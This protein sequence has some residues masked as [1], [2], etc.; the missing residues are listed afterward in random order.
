MSV[1]AE[2][3]QAAGLTDSGSEPITILLCSYIEK[4]ATLRAQRWHETVTRARRSYDTG[5]RLG[6]LQN[7]KKLRSLS[8]QADDQCRTQ[9]TPRDPTPP[10][11][12]NATRTKILRHHMARHARYRLSRQ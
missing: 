12:V 8:A 9:A 7:P 10:H 4:G 2:R 5:D 1:V 3:T 11:S 6:A